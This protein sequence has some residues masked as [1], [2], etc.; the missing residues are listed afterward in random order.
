MTNI[1]SLKNLN[2]ALV[3]KSLSPKEKLLVYA[4]SL[5]III[6]VII[7]GVKFYYSNTESAPRSGG[8][9][10]EASL[11]APRFINPVL[12]QVNDTDRDITRLIYSGLVRYN[13]DGTLVGDLAE[14]YSIENNTIYKFTLKENILWHDGEA[15]TADDIVF[16]IKIIQDPKYASPIRSNWQGVEAEKIDEKTVLIKLTSTYSPFLENTTIGILPKHI[17]E[18]ISPKSFA[19][20]DE[21]LKAI[22]SG[23]YKFNNFQKDRDGNIISYSL[24]ANKKYY[25]DPPHIEQINFKFFESETDALKAI[26]SGEIDSMSL[27]SGY[28]SEK[29]A[30]RND[31]EIRKF[32]LPRYFAIF[33]NQSN[34]KIL[35]EKV[36]REALAISINRTELIDLA[37]NGQAQSAYGPIVRELLGYNPQVE[38]KYEFSPQEAKRRLEA[39]NWKDINGDGIMEKRFDSA[40]EPTPL[41]FT[42]T[43]VGW[44]G[45][46]ELEK[47]AN[48]LQRQWEE[49]GVKVNIE[50][51]PPGEL[52][53]NFIRPRE[54]EALLFGQIVGIDPD[55]F[56]FWHSSQKKDPGLNIAL[57]ENK[58]TDK[59][60]EEAR[61]TFDSKT[62]SDKYVEFQNIIADDLPAIFLYSPTYLY[63][64]NKNVNGISEGKI[65]DPSWR[66][67]DINEWYIKTKRI[68]K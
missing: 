45:F 40:E 21:N 33:F 42:L 44:P 50:I 25:F 46:S 51:Y 22:G 36:V 59:L 47:A 17:W 37:T 23:P 49:I 57:Y 54:Y 63:P 39:A 48:A 14:S 61:Q 27:I 38:E 5:A 13:K 3:W 16:T 67:A 34:S 68:W 19:L 18:N 62:R 24:R 15:L 41:E 20:A 29:L 56:S 2:W 28:N 11:E 10:R 4:F 7:L 9:F 31:I 64:V 43:T 58:R 66:F 65:S 1:Q 52:Q 60:L 35:K 26:K 8:A 55:P 32:S 53:Q 12:A 6:S 30:N